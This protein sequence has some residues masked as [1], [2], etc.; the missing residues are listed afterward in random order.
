MHLVCL[1]FDGTV[2]VYDDGPGHFHPEVILFLNELE[3]RGIR[4]CSNSGRD[5]A[6]Q[7]RVLKASAARGLRHG[8]DA[9]VCS[10]Y[11]VY[12]REGATYADLDPWNSEASRRL[13][14]LHGRVRRRLEPERERLEASYQP[15]LTFGNEALMAYL[16]DEE[17]DRPRRFCAELDV[18]LAEVPDWMVSRNGGWISLLHR[19]LGKGHALAAYAR[20]RGIEARHILAV[21]DQ[22]N[23]LPM[24]DGAAAGLVGCPGNAIAEVQSA[25][26]TKAGY[27][28]R[29]PAPEGTLDV[30]RHFIS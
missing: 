16:L 8:P 15:K 1:D 23:D 6:D 3:G 11:L 29:R 26:K 17:E 25:V 7:E 18:L 5:R 28:A 22:L 19:A 2:M 14:D 10:E 24:L 30:L 27:V 21:G 4:W 13:A 12:V 9:L 20:H